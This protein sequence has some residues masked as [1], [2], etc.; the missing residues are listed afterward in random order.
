[1][2]RRLVLAAIIIGLAAAPSLSYIF[3][4]LEINATVYETR[5]V[6]FNISMTTEEPLE[7]M[8]LSF[9]AR[10]VSPSIS[11][12][13]T[14]SHS[15]HAL[16]T[17]IK[18]RGNI[19]SVSVNART[20]GLVSE[21]DN[22]LMFYLRI[23]VLN[24]YRN[25][26]FRISLP[27]GFILSD[28]Q[29]FEKFGYSVVEPAGYNISTDGRRIYVLWRMNNP[30]LGRPIEFRVIYERTEEGGGGYLYLAAIPAAV[31]LV[32]LL[33]LSRRRVRHFIH[34]LDADEKRVYEAIEGRKVKQSRLVRELD[35]SKAKLSRVV[36]RLEEKGLVRKE[37][38]GRDNIL[39]VVK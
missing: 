39:E 31:M 13:G 16:G 22:S 26:T 8:E 32:A 5:D 7:S 3:T 24:V 12:N 1:M 19:T 27:E 2:L 30:E 35:M 28:R 17:I 38:R 36:K 37:R 29:Y 4:S 21:L 20:I 18:C 6:I 11:A 15:Y 25:A 10:L 14:C 9:P 23:P 34:A 33:F